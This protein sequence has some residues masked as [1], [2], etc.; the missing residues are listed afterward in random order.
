MKTANKLLLA[1]CAMLALP[2]FSHAACHANPSVDNPGGIQPHRILTQEKATIN[3]PRNSFNVGDV[4]FTSH[5]LYNDGPV[6]STTC[7]GVA[8][9]YEWGEI[10]GGPLAGLSKIPALSNA[11]R[12]V[13]QTSVPG[14]GIALYFYDDAADSYGSPR[15]P[16]YTV[17]DRT[18]LK[19]LGDPNWASTYR[20]TGDFQYEL[21]RTA[22][23][24][25]P[26]GNVSLNGTFA[27][28]W[29]GGSTP[30]GAGSVYST[31]LSIPFDIYITST[32]CQ[33]LN[34]SVFVQLPKV[35]VSDLPY[36]D[37]AT[38]MAPFDINLSCSDGKVSY[39]IAA[40]KLSAGYYSL[41]K[42]QV[43]PGAA[44]GVNVQLLDRSTGI[45]INLNDGKYLLAGS[46]PSL[47]D[48]TPLTI[49]LAARYY[50]PSG[51][52]LQPGSV[53]ALAYLNLSYD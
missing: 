48:S 15:R 38:G 35:S 33:V 5:R 43:T 26:P 53:Q 19:W 50:R 46:T 47:P 44:T 17:A 12:A 20:Q 25:I 42:P 23:N 14:I 22:P 40:D 49:K 2:A 32:T 36:S 37:T 34:P 8:S 51:S 3:V 28:V 29:M 13:Y 27:K 11:S 1:G 24:L 52:T 16:L 30:G 4:I 21:I 9:D 18:A 6:N 41:I 45:G 31:D 10:T 7:D 39:T